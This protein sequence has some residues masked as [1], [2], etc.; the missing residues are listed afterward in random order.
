MYRGVKW[1]I[2]GYEQDTGD[3]M[4]DFRRYLN[5]RISGGG[6]V[7]SSVD[8][9]VN[10]LKTQT[11][12]SEELRT[13][14]SQMGLPL[15]KRLPNEPGEGTQFGSWAE[16]RQ[17]MINHPNLRTDATQSVLAQSHSQSHATQQVDHVDH[18]PDV[19]TFE[20]A[21]PI[22]EEQE[23]QEQEEILPAIV[24]AIANDTRASAG[25][26]EAFRAVLQ[27]YIRNILPLRHQDNSSFFQKVSKML[28]EY[29]TTT[30][31]GQVVG[32]LV[33]MYNK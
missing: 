6:N 21:S 3:R 4:T 25:S 9:V 27:F 28:F 31:A 2:E 16:V 29:F 5:H 26:K 18:V 30:T 19:N 1:V 8:N 13:L 15:D 14:K 32:L 33:N 22:Q 17:F 24:Q 23:E 11:Y 12:S 20:V 10:N 7:H